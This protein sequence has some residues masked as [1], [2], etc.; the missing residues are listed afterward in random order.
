MMTPIYRADD[1]VFVVSH[2]WDMFALGVQVSALRAQFESVVST[3]LSSLAI[4]QSTNITTAQCTR[5]LPP[6]SQSVPKQRI[7]TGWGAVHK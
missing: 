3:A 2:V 6:H 5:S 4:S 7:M 1:F